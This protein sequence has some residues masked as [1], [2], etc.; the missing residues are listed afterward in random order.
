MKLKLSENMAKDACEVHLY[1]A[2]G[3]LGNFIRIIKKNI[4]KFIKKI[5]NIY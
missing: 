4:F 3:Y 2:W 5:A 1:V